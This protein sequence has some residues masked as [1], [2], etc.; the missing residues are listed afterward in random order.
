MCALADANHFSKDDDHESPHYKRNMAEHPKGGRMDD[1]TIIV[2]LVAN[3]GDNE[4]QQDIKTNGIIKKAS[5]LIDRWMK[6][7]EMISDEEHEG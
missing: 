2:A 3:H 7:M 4:V 1:M 5:G 6:K